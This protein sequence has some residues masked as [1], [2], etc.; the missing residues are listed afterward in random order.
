MPDLERRL[1]V[2][3]PHLYDGVSLVDAAARAGVPLRTATRWLAVYRADGAAGLT[4]S[5]RVDWGGRRIRRE[6]VELIEGLALRRP[7]PRIAQVH[8]AA[9]KVADDRV[10]ALRRISQS[11]GTCR[12]LTEDCSR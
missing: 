1:A 3:S 8:R 5:A 6:L 10:G 11:A 9:S 7:P 2:L 4:R 12:D